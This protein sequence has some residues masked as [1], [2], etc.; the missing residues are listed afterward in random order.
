MIQLRN[1][2]AGPV[3][4]FGTPD[5][6]GSLHVDVDQVIEVPGELVTDLEGQPDDCIVIRLPNGDLRAWSTAVWEHADAAPP[7]EPATEQPLAEPASSI[8]T[9]Q[10]P[11]ELFTP[12]APTAPAATPTNE[13]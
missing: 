10:P 1:K 9:A 3:S 13:G 12:T 4:L 8:S 5:E 11:A 7:S 2:H 6:V